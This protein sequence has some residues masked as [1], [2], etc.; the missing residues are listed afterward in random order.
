MLSPIG[1]TR[2]RRGGRTLAAIRSLGFNTV[3]TWAEWSAAE[4]REGEYRFRTARTPVE[5]AEEAGLKVIVQVYVDSAPEWV[6]RK[7]PDGQF[8][9]SGRHCDPIAGGP[10]YCFDHPGVRR[11]VL[12]FSRKSRGARRGARL[13][14]RTTCGASRR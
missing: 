10:G 6:G 9:S 11:A 3:R 4:A 12:R 1:R 2:K 5:L 7:F 14:S 13:S 8:V